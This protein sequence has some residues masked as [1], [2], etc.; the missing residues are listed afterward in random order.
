M[1][2]SIHVTM[3][4]LESKSLYC[5]A[6]ELAPVSDFRQKY[7]GSNSA[8]GQGFNGARGWTSAG[9]AE[10]QSPLQRRFY[11]HPDSPATGEHWMQNSQNFNKLKLTNNAMDK[12]S[13]VSDYLPSY[14]L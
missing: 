7:I 3:E 6:I 12:N 14:A 13:N 8:E 9:P 5:I 4:G 2:P 1:F 11:L 10:P